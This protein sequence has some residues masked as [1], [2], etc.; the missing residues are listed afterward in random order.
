MIGIYKIT[1]PTKK[2]YIGQSVDIERRK[3]EYKLKHCK[4]QVALYRSINKYG[5][6]KH[7][8]KVID[9]CDIKDLNEKERYYQDLYSSVGVSGLNMKLTSTKD[10]SGYFSQEIKDKIS[11]SNKGKVRTLEM[12]IHLSNINKGKKHSKETILKFMGRKTRLGVKLSD[13]QKQKTSKKC[14]DLYTGIFY[15]SIKK[16]AN[17]LC[18][19]ERGLARKLRGERNNNTNVIL[20]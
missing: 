19:N 9:Y 14:V 1:S 16:C 6:D 3:K 7:I 20:I 10:K 12:K 11:K 5:W 4:N 13:E 18:I 2:I 15:D 8:F 17:A